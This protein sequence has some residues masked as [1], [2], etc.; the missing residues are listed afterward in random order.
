MQIIFLGNQ[1]KREVQQ[2]AFN[3][4]SVIVYKDI[5]VYKIASDNPFY[6]TKI[7]LEKVLKLIKEN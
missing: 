7:L 6:F 4:S 2:T 1:L 5:I 3:H